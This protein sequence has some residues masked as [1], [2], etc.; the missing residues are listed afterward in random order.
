MLSRGTFSEFMDDVESGRVSSVRLDGEIIDVVSETGEKYR[1]VRPIGNDVV[2]PLRENNIEIQ[3]VKQAQSGLM[4]TI[5]VWLP[6]ILLIGIWIFLMNRMQG[7]GRGGA[8]GFGK[9]KAK[10]LTEKHGRVTFND[11]AGIDEAKDEL[12]E[13]VEFLKDPQKF[14]ELGGKN[15][16][17]S[18]VGRASWYW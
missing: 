14:G 18:I 4:S 10:L 7:G 1:V 15:S 9:S 12:E 17:R 2:T 5:S 8:L 3:A 6:F 16:E 11:V 13:I